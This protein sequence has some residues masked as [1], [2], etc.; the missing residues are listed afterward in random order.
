MRVV[1]VCKVSIPESSTGVKA[2]KPFHVKPPDRNW[3]QR[4]LHAELNSAS[5]ISRALD[6][7]RTLLQS[8]CDQEATAV[9][10]H[11]L[12]GQALP[13]LSALKSSLGRMRVTPERRDEV[14]Q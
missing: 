13:L 2:L 1:L 7:L 11:F 12:R 14:P 6:S 8:F 4:K 9:Q 3:T 10:S 5:E